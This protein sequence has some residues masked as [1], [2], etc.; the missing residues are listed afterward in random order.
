MRISSS[1]TALAIL[2]TAGRAH[3]LTLSSAAFANEAAIPPKHSCTD[4]NVSPPLGWQEVPDGVK[5]FAMV[6]DDPDAPA[7]TWVHWVLYDIPG[8]TRELPV[9]VPTIERGAGGMKQG[10]NDFQH[11]GWGG[12][13]PPPGPG[14][15]YVFRLYALD[16]PSGLA[17]GASKADLTS[18]MRGHVLGEATLVGTFE[19]GAETKPAH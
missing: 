6:V 19:R 18:A 11:I 10:K 2:L 17:P 16:A 7:G 4:A 15:K 8:D 9:G 5:A 3:A 1:L 14:H 13:C 12:P